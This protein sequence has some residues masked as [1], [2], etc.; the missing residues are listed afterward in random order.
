MVSLTGDLALA[1]S[2]LSW[3]RKAS[4]SVMSASSW[5]VTCGII[6]QFRCRLAP[7]IFLMRDSGFF[8]TGP[9]FSKSTF[10]HGSR[11]SAAPLAPPAAAA[12]AGAWP[13][14][15]ASRFL[16]KPF[17]SSA[18]M[19]SFGPEPLTAPRSTPSS[20]A[21]RRTDGEA[22][23]SARTA[24]SASSAG[25]AGVRGEPAG[26]AADE[27]AGWAGAAAWA[28]AGAWA[29]AGCEAAGA[30][31]AWAAAWAGAAAAGWAAGALTGAAAPPASILPSTEP[32]DTLSPSL[33][34][35]DVMRPAAALGI[36]MDA[37]SD[38]TVTRLCSAA[39]SSPSFT[40]ISMT[41]TSEKSPIS[42]T[43][44]SITLMSA[45]TS[46]SVFVG[47]ASTGSILSGLMPYFLIASATF[48]AG[49]VPSSA[50][51]CRAASTTK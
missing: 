37:L 7:E 43:T 16:T 41:S 19:R 46:R 2:A 49:M 17:T 29:A 28:D 25:T 47:Q 44:I 36:S 38:S 22:C 45:D 1:F 23:G 33:T 18:V 6:T 10:G 21:S 9:N 3:T 12:P 30:G 13:A 51:A 31:A 5:L 24:P 26:A 8:S 20:R 34:V 27:A 35:S 50:R 11:P 4:R 15:P 39:T 14:P 40:R 42:G 48:V 32:F